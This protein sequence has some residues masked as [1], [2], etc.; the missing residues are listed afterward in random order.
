M[1]DAA[2]R[3]LVV[4]DKRDM[5]ETCRRILIRLGHDVEV[6]ASGIEGQGALERSPFDLLITDL[7]M[8][9][10]DGITL[11]RWAR[12]RIP[13]LAV[14]VITAHATIETALRATRDG[15]CDFIPK[16]FGMEEFEVAVTRSLELGRLREENARLKSRVA[17]E[18]PTE[19][20]I[21][22]S[23][24]I[25]GA[26]DLV[27]RI[28]DSD[29]SVLVTGES[30]TGKELVAR[31]IHARSTRRD[32]T[33]VPLDCAALPETLLESELF[34]AE[35]GSY[36]GAVAA[37][38][39]IF[40]IASRS[41][42]F[43]DEI[44]NLPLA[45]QV[46]LLRVLQERS[47]RRLGGAGQI[48]VDVRLIAASNQDLSLMVQDGRFRKDLF[49]R[50]NVVHIVLPPL[51]E[52]GED[53][54]ILARRFTQ[55]LA[56]RHKRP[57]EGVSAAAMMFL[58]R[59]QW[60]GN[61]REL[62]NVLERA[63]LLSESNQVMPSDLPAALLDTPTARPASGDFNTAKRRVT[64]EFEVAYLRALL[65]QTGGNISR[66]AT[67]AGLQR[68][69]LHRLLQ[70]HGLKAEDFRPASPGDGVTLS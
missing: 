15:A 24:Q 64:R 9:D 34:G 31:L 29:A 63:V 44:S 65:E 12:Q 42:I 35:R 33:F 14:L 7:V 49:Y 16:P 1:A 20:V 3:I 6:A 50:L 55:E 48:D 56:T 17:A 52:R 4:D 38:A 68:T 2:R 66:A 45:T 30:G 46:K 41:T 19:T 36:T 37:R 61:V 47:V 11:A 10:M 23:P 26:L 8:P 32:R 58:K 21:G 43:L 67:L 39:G 70:R 18:E 69:A 60:P 54:A 22:Q 25:L 62:R 13:Q 28:A 57:V 53:V 5:L 27:A 51:R 59:Y 40:E